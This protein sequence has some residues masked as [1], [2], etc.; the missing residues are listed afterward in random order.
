MCD[1]WI[2]KY[3]FSKTTLGDPITAE[4]LRC[5]QRPRVSGPTD[6]LSR[7]AVEDDRRTRARFPEPDIV[8]RDETATIVSDQQISVILLLDRVSNAFC[9]Q[10]EGIRRRNDACEEK[11]GMVD[12]FLPLRERDRRTRREPQG[13]VIALAGRKTGKDSTFLIRVSRE[14]LGEMMLPRKADGV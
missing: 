11:S 13:Q 3:I 10:Q 12:G 7:S 8:L 1:L 6:A 5:D 9:E 2:H 4:V 14:S